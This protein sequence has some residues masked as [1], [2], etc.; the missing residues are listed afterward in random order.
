MILSMTVEGMGG[1]PGMLTILDEYTR[2]V[3]DTLLGARKYLW[4]D[5]DENTII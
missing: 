2:E 5:G 1:R 3:F 4:S